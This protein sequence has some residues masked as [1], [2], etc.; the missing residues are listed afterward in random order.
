VTPSLAGLLLGYGNGY[1]ALAAHS[2]SQ[3]RGGMLAAC[4]PI[5]IPRDGQ[6]L[7]ADWPPSLVFAASLALT[8]HVSCRREHSGRDARAAF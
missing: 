3:A 2:S 1:I 7:T 5:D 8:A 4:S 6:R